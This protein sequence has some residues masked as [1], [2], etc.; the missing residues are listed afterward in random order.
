M[1]NDVLKTSIMIHVKLLPKYP[2][3]SENAKRDVM[4]AGAMACINDIVI[5]E[6]L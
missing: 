3:F 6:M 2:D 4:K 1:S 5:W